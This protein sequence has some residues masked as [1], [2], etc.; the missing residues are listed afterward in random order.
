MKRLVLA[1]GGHAH[2]EVLRSFGTTPMPGLEIILVT[3]V[4][5]APYSGMLPGLIA[6]HYAWRDCH[7]DLAALARF[8]GA[9]L[10]PTR[11]I[12]INPGDRQVMCADRRVLDY[13]AL[14]LDVGSAPPIGGID[15][16][17]EHGISV[18][19]VDSFLEVW[20]ALVLEARDR[21][22]RVAVVGGGAGGVELCLAMRHRLLHESGEAPRTDFTL[23]TQGG[24]IL[25]GHSERVRRRLVRALAKSGVGLLA[26]VR[27][28]RVAGAGLTLDGGA[29]VPADCVVWA[30]GAAAPA[31]LAKSGLSLGRAR[32]RPRRRDARLDRASRCLRGRRCRD[33][34]RSSAAEVRC[35]RRTARATPRGESSARPRRTAHEALPAAATQSLAD[36]HRR[37]ARRGF[38]G[39]TLVPG[40][41]GLALEGFDRSKVHGEVRCPQGLNG[42]RV[43]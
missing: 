35:L 11:V 9:R 23:V 32:L 43:R 27:V 24:A 20:D 12:A 8:A 37:K 26:G 33:H 22:L 42:M 40:A 25:P 39:R 18:K 38:M 34:A 14:S 19:P 30:T 10:I 2:V 6:G 5:D 1:G 21:P 41:M 17:M 3:P 4:A 31:W 15:G 13:D 28:A 29:L 16:A 7:I 36:Q